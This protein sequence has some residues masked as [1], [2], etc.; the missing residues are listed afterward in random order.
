MIGDSISSK[1]R[2]MHQPC[3]VQ[4]QSPS[5]KMSTKTGLPQLKVFVQSDIRAPLY[6]RGDHTDGFSVLEREDMMN[7]YL[8]RVKHD[9]PTEMCDLIL[10]RLTGRARDMVKVPLRSCSDPSPSDL[11]LAVFEAL[12]CNFSPLSYSSFSKKY[13]YST[14]SVWWPPQT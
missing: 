3:T 9:T 10:W 1:L 14:A 5:S 13:V 2:I 4:P 6:F 11:P 7:G 8:K 12:K